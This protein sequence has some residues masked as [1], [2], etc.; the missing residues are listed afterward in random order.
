MAP[1]M[2]IVPPPP[3]G[4]PD[5]NDVSKLLPVDK[6]EL[7][8]WKQEYARAS[9][10]KNEYVDH[11]SKAYIVIIQQC[12]AALCDNLEADKTF[13]TVRYNQD[14]LALLK[15]IQGLCCS[16]DSKVQSVM[17]TVVSHKRLYTYYQHDGVD[18]HTYQCK[19]MSFV[20]TIKTYGGLGAVGVIPTF[21][22]DKIKVLH[23]QGLIAD[24]TNPTDDER[25]LAVGAICEEYLAALMLSGAN[26]DRFS[27]LR[28]DLQNQFGYG[29]NL[30][31]KTTDQGLSLLNRWTT[32]PPRAKR[33]WTNAKAPVQPKQEDNEALVFAQDGAHGRTPKPDADTHKKGAQKPSS[34]SLSSSTS[35]RSHRQITTVRCK[36]CGHAEHA[37][38]VCPDNNNLPPA[39]I[40]AMDAN[41]ASKA[42]DESSVIILAQLL[43]WSPDKPC[44]PINKDFVLL[45]SQ[46]TVNLFSSPQHVTNIRPADTPIR[47]HC[48]KGTMV[49]TEQADFG[50]N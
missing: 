48:N 14:P 16:Y 38:A 17:A 22:K 31:P 32:T 29:N 39:Q 9:K 20:E 44:Q 18:N 28:T 21:L 13:P 42:S 24:A 36:N 47:V 23:T 46:S 2:I 34:K 35:S 49:T 40:H 50:N 37:S 8:L 5:P 4:K 45:G 12:S 7:Y 11:L 19:F 27:L 41:D 26:R 10:K 15:L 1:V 6:I 33:D 43:D 25:A 30:Y 3:Q